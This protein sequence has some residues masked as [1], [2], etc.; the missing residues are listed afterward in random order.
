[1]PHL[2]EKTADKPIGMDAIG[3]SSTAPCSDFPIREA[4]EGYLSGT[5]GLPTVMVTSGRILNSPVK[6]ESFG[7]SEDVSR[8]SSVDDV[9]ATPLGHSTKHSVVTPS[10]FTNRGERFGPIVTIYGTKKLSASP[11]R[12]KRRVSNSEDD[13]EDEPVVPGMSAPT[14]LRYV[15]SYST[16]TKTA[17]K[18]ESESRDCTSKRLLDQLEGEQSSTKRQKSERTESPASVPSMPDESSQTS[19][20]STNV[21]QKK[22]LITPTSSNEKVDEDEAA[23]TMHRGQVFPPYGHKGYPRAPFPHHL[24]YPGPPGYGPPP[25]P[26]YHGYPPY[27]VYGMPPPM[28]GSP[29]FP[30]YPPHPGMMRPFP[31]RV[32]PPGKVHPHFMGSPARMHP[33]PEDDASTPSNAKPDAEA[34][35]SVADWQQAAL[36]NGKPPSANRC[37]PLKEPIPSK[38]WGNAEKTKDV[39]LPDFH[40]L[41]N[42]PDYLAKSRSAAG[43]ASAAASGKKNCVMCGKLRVCSASSLVARNRGAAKGD[44]AASAGTDGEDESTAHIIPRQNK[45]LCTACDVSVWVV[46]NDG[47]EIK[48]CKG[49]KNFRPWAAFGDKGSATK[50]TR[51]RDRQREKYAMQKDEIRQRRCKRSAS[52]SPG[53][54]DKT[55]EDNCSEEETHMAAAAGLR[56]L[57]NA[58]TA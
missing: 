14:N 55:E 51:C 12:V 23:A 46:V 32:P 40:R 4:R 5:E 24:A 31:G 43:E 1:M 57:M 56:N 47:L 48:W 11:I 18:A 3:T 13:N 35:R 17:Q 7:S 44:D 49:C 52:N 6:V 39:A 27:G 26:H 58:G 20:R 36:T 9:T 28:M 30:G 10:P 38:Y 37:V 15:D 19:P 54:D 29:F 45:G 16:P 34:I 22:P 50:C 2:Q 8:V 33:K 21:R 41:V 42:Y 53:N 25:H